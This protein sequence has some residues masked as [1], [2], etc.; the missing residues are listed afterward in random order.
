M[1]L[2]P[3]RR[4]SVLATPAECSARFTVVL[5]DIEST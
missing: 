5:R 2:A 1:K 4:G 3:S